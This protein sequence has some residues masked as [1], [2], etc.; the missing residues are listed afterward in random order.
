MAI[1]LRTLK[2]GWIFP[3]LIF[4]AMGAG[5]LLGFSNINLPDLD[6]FN[7]FFFFAVLGFFG[8]IGIFF[9]GFSKLRQKRTIENL[10]TSKI[11]SIAMGLV[12][13]S[14]EVAPL[15]VN[16][17]KSPLTQN[18]CVHYS[19]AVEEY[20][21]SGKSSHWATLL[22]DTQSYPFSLKDD[23][24]EVLVDPKDAEID[25][26]NDFTFESGLG[27]PPPAS[28]K[29]FLTA[30]SLSFE[31]FL[32]FNKRMRFTESFI[33]PKDKLFV[34]GTAG[35]NPYVEEATAQKGVEDVMIQKGRLG[36]FYYISDR[37]EKEVLK[38][39]RWKVI[40][41][42]YGGSALSLGSLTV[43]LLYLGLF[44]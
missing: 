18:D 12:E 34:I 44:F 14:G 36:S 40:G 26:P 3:L 35:D 23:T 28:I 22:S 9:Y 15:K 27:K 13:V 16:M 43:I 4:A 42:I 8:G 10:P 11:R 21:R 1:P 31:S 37:P 41:G 25:I 30:R 20:R 17:L 24:G 5:I 6:R 2:S 32:G 39:F 29:Q 7:E 19:F 33:A 38:K